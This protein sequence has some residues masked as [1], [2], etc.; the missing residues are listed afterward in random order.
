M[1]YLQNHISVV[2]VV[3]GGGV[4]PFGTKAYAETTMTKFRPHSCSSWWRHQMET[5]SALLAIC[6]GNSPVPGEFPTQ[7][8]VTRSFDVCFD[9][10]PNKRLSKQSWVWWFETLSRPFWRHSNVNSSTG[11][12]DVSVT[13]EIIGL[14]LIITHLNHRCC[15]IF[16]YCL[17]TKRA[18]VY[19][20]VR[21]SVKGVFIGAWIKLTIQVPAPYLYSSL[22]RLCTRHTS[23]CLGRT[24]QPAYSSQFIR[25]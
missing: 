16:S 19:V 13:Y 12:D 8:P 11:A 14:L 6:A 25:F 10:R 17:I 7:R 5:F 4:A 23:E 2:M 22:L 24:A 1:E 20:C 9:L 3:A 18:C 21:V 15:F